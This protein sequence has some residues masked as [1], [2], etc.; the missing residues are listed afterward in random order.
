MYIPRVSYFGNQY[1]SL[2]HQSPLPPLL[3]YYYLC[4]FVLIFRSLVSY[5]TLQTTDREFSSFLA[6]VI[7]SRKL[8]PPS[9]SQILCYFCIL[10]YFST[11]KD[12]PMILSWLP[13]LSFN[14]TH[15]NGNAVSSTSEMSQ[16]F[17]NFTFFVFREK[18]LRMTLC[19]C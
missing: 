8:D 1:F 7:H 3:H 10:Y 2:P 13:P 6:W 18:L 17:G 19:L 16:E 15:Q 9:F 11:L 5:F 14:L 4:D 12:F